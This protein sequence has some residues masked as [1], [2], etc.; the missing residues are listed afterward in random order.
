MKCRIT[1]LEMEL[2]IIN[3]SKYIYEL[4]NTIKELRESTIK[5]QA[6]IDYTEEPLSKKVIKLI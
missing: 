1:S 3:N 4:Q 2:T 6:K 5:L